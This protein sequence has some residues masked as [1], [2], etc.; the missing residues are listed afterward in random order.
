MAQ[1]DLQGLLLSRRMSKN[2]LNKPFPLPEGVHFHPHRAGWRAD[3]QC[4]LGAVL[5]RARDPGGRDH[6][7][8]QA[9][10]TCGTKA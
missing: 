1:K 10:E 3:G 5:P 6:S 8:P 4:L 2:R 9:R 7:W